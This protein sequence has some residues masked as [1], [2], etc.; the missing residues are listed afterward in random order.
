[1]IDDLHQKSTRV[2]EMMKK[3]SK[4]LSE[5]QMP[6][7]RESIIKNSGL[8]SRPDVETY[9]KKSKKKIDDVTKSLYD[10]AFETGEIK[11]F[12]KRLELDPKFK[13]AVEKAYG[14]M[15]PLDKGKPTY[16]KFSVRNLHD[17]KDY[18]HDDV[19]RFAKSGENKEKMV[20]SKVYNEL[21][22]VLNEASPDYK[23]ATSIY[24]KYFDIQRAAESGK[25]F[26]NQNIDD[27]IKNLGIMGGR[28]RHAYKTGAVQS[29]LEKAEARSQNAK[30]AELG[31]DFTNPEIKRKLETIIGEEK[32]NNIVKDIDAS[33]EAVENIRGITKGSDTAKHM[34]NKNL[35][36][37]TFGAAKG[38]VK[39]IINLIFGIGEKVKEDKAAREAALKMH[40][41]M[42][43]KKL[44]QYQNVPVKEVSNIT[45]TL[46]GLQTGRGNEKDRERAEEVAAA[47][48]RIAKAPTLDEK[49]A[50]IH[51]E[52]AA[53]RAA[54]RKKY[55]Y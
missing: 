54:R 53:K 46:Y 15:H 7:I 49:I 24:K 23:K 47:T 27:M 8:H 36:K 37:N 30:L 18:I 34:S 55:G 11:N 28:E 32:L 2:R 42:N 20:A 22:D 1:M 13:P 6:H 26:K 19:A 21:K 9:V 4:R 48:R 31:K 44:L 40:L 43:P 33:N 12:P 41:F 35:F 29:L 51:A 10:R 52:Y 3:E 45:P 5:G 25:E 50:A 17:T 38:S 14:N 39:G 16:E